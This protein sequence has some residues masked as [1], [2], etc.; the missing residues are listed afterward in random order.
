[1]NK[2]HEFDSI[3]QWANAT[4]DQM[5]DAIVCAISRILCTTRF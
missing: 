2:K 4:H 5:R 1:M 3:I